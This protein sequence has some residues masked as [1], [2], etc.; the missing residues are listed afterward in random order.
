MTRPQE[1]TD[2]LEGPVDGSGQ[3]PRLGLVLSGGGS[4]GLAHVG[5]LR[6]LM[7]QGIFPDCAAGSSSG[8]I[9]GAL[10]AAGHSAAKMLEFFQTVNPYRVRPLRPRAPARG[11]DSDP[12]V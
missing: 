6:A 4:R 3:R 11:A 7:E 1:R 8:A 10:Y 5:V 12:D 9:V 2:A